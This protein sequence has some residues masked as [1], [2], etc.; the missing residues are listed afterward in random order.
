METFAFTE[1]FS[2]KNIPI[3]GAQEYLKQLVYSIEKLINNCRLKVEHFEKEFSTD[4]KVRNEPPKHPDA[5]NMFH[6]KEMYGFKSGKAR[7]PHHDLHKFEQ[8]LLKL[9]KDVQFRKISNKFQRKLNSELDEMK[10]S[11]DIFVPADKSRN[12]YKLSPQETEKLTIDNITKDYRLIEKTAVNA[13]DLKAK[14]IATTLGNGLEY[15]MQVY[16]PKEAYV[17]LK[18]TKEDFKSNKPCRVINGAKTDVGKISKILIR[19]IIEEILPQTGLNLWKSTPD[20]LRWF[21]TIKSKPNMVKTRKNTTKFLVFDIEKYYPSISENLVRNA[22][23]FAQKFCFISQSDINI[24]MT[25][26]E[27]FLF[28]KEKVYVKKIQP[29]FD[30]PMG[31]WDGAEISELCGIYLLYK[32]TRNDGTGPNGPFKKEE[33]GLYRDD[34]LAAVQGTNKERDAI[35]TKIKN[36][37]AEENLKV[38]QKVN[39]LVVDYLDMTLDLEVN[40]HRPFHKAKP[41]YIHKDSNHPQHIIKEIPKMIQKRISMLSSDEEIFKNA[42]G[43]Y[44]EALLKSGYDIDEGSGNELKFTPNTKSRKRKSRPTIWF[45]PPFALSVKTN[46]GARFLHLITKHFPK[47]HRF[48][49]LFN[50]NNLKLSYSTTR[51]MASHIST[52]NKKVLNP[53]MEAQVEKC[54]HRAYPCPLQDRCN[55]GPLVYQA[56]VS[57][58]NTTKTYYGLAGT[59][60]KKRYGGHRSNLENREDYGTGLSKYVWFLK[61]KNVT[62]DLKWSIKKKAQVY[63]EGAKYCDLCLTEKTIIMLADKNCINIRTE[64]LRKC[65]HIRKFTLGMVKP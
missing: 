7:E 17:T 2:T 62:F 54:T 56:D 40:K 58:T 3:P 65:P 47:G 16:T 63:S 13:V 33:V 43:P 50:R 46:I 11:K 23:K 18:D 19:R 21:D 6:G 45:N 28:Y 31:S 44:K 35:K 34:G 32:L 55:E 49:K 25:A 37:F 5:L 4:P 26:R 12:Y 30:V 57:T 64:I 38:E 53:K 41:I 59:T 60:F 8:D 14:E 10:K 15:M 52:H 42:I 51:N 22:I 27:S 24:I 61:D 9:P 39:I 20:V 48:H 1:D 29:Q 36:I